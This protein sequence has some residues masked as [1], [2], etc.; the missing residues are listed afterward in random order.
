[1]TRREDLASITLLASWEILNER[2]ARVFTNKL[3]PP[4]VLL[5]KIKYE[6]KP[7]HKAHE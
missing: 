5:R 6:A 2:N 4:S 3:A 1:M 7:G